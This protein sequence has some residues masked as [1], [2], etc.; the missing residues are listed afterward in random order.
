MNYA[1]REAYH[2]RIGIQLFWSP[3]PMPSISSS[4]SHVQDVVHPYIK[5]RIWSLLGNPTVLYLQS[6]QSHC[7]DAVE[8]VGDGQ[9]KDEHVKLVDS[10]SGDQR[11][12]ALFSVTRELSSNPCSFEMNPI[13]RQ[14]DFW[15]TSLWIKLDEHEGTWTTAKASTVAILFYHNLLLVPIIQNAGNCIKKKKHRWQKPG[16]MF[17][18]ILCSLSVLSV[19]LPKLTMEIYRSDKGNLTFAAHLSDPPPPAKIR[20]K[21]PAETESWRS[22]RPL[23]LESCEW[24]SALVV[25]GSSPG[26]HGCHESPTLLGTHIL[27]M[28]VWPTVRSKDMKPISISSVMEKTTA[29]REL[30]MML[31]IKIM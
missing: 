12:F 26:L 2:V 18:L 20:R 29:M 5:H 14:W 11:N 19:R 3:V 21:T 27:E 6:T 31:E 13:D 1:S 30:L 24:P 7:A 4:V 15:A 28:R 8:D 10:I 9:D 22:L 23:V 16:N 25:A 17:P